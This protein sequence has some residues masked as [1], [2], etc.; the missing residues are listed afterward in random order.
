MMQSSFLI[1]NHQSANFDNY[2]LMMKKRKTTTVASNLS[3]MGERPTIE[4][5]GLKQNNLTWFGTM[6]KPDVYGAVK[7]KMP[8]ARDGHSSMVIGD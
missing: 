4:S 5:P 6:K 8:A 1:K 7:G 3:H 2:L